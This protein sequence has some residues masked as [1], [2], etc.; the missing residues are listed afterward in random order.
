MIEEEPKS[1]RR[2]DIKRDGSPLEE[3]DSQRIAS[4][5]G[6]ISSIRDSEI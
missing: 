2:D 3:F 5:E 1:T 4:S 6:D